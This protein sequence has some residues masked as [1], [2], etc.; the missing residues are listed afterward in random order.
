MKVYAISLLSMAIL[1]LADPQCE[2]LSETA[3]QRLNEYVQRKF[4]LQPSTVLTISSAEFVSSTCFR[5]LTF[6]SKSNPASLKLVLFLSPDQRFLANDLFDTTVE[7]ADRRHIEQERLQSA[8]MD[9]DFPVRGPR[10]APVTVMMFSDFQCPYCRKQVEIL[11]ESEFPEQSAIRLVF[12]NLPLQMH[13]W[14]R[15]A[16]EMAACVYAQSNEAFWRVHDQLFKNQ[17]KIKPSNLARIVE[18]AIAN[19]I[20][21]N[22]NRYRNCV[23]RREADERVSRDIAFAEDHGLSG[24]PT[25]IINGVRKDGIAQMDE[26]RALVRNALSKVANSATTH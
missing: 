25:L 1:S 24:T 18:S 7:P 20:D 4:N 17:I 19:R 9:G 15:P 21:V 3:H 11:E 26:F 23:V 10:N 16:A 14:A 2:P 5:K 12:R 22:L 13:P 6:R 8:V